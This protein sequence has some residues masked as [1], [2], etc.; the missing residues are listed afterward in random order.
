[1]TFLSQFVLGSKGMPR[2]YA[3]Y[4]EQFQPLHAF[5]TYGSWVL[6]AGLFMIAIYLLAT[7]RK[8]MDA[9]ANPWGARTLDWEATAAVPIAH[10][11]D[12]VPVLT[13]GPY[14][15]RPAAARTNA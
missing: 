7:F 9:P 10:N 11:F 13:H 14:D 15:Y 5:S 4:L 1:M 8:P 12:H 2:R 3:N 6:G